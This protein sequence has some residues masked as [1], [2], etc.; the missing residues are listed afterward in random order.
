MSNLLKIRALGRFEA[1]KNNQIIDFLAKKAQALL[2]YLA[3]SPAR[4]TRG[5]LATLLWSEFSEERGR[6]NLRQVLSKL[7]RDLGE[8]VLS[9]G[10]TIELDGQQCHCD[11][12]E[13]EQLAKS[14]NSEDLLKALDLFRGDFLH[15]FILRE[16]SFDDW[17]ILQRSQL[18]RVA[19]EISDRLIN[20]FSIE[21]DEQLT[22]VLNRR[23]SMD[24]A[25][26]PAHRKM[27]ELYARTGRR[28][29]AQR[30]Y[31]DCCEILRRELDAEPS[32]E[33]KQLFATIQQGGY[34]NKKTSIPKEENTNA[35]SVSRDIPR[36]AIMPF[37]IIPKDADSYFADGM[38]EDIIMAL[39]RFGSLQVISRES[40]FTYQNQDK[41]DK[42]IA[43]ELSADYL[44]RGSVQ[45]AGD[46]LR[47]NVKLLETSSGVQLWG[48]RF[49][50][51]LQDIFLLQDEISS[52][53][54]SI[55]VG[56]VEAARLANARKAPPE[57][58]DAYDMLL[59]GKEYHHRFTAED[60]RQCINMFEQAI[61]RDPEYAVAYAWLACGFGQAMVF[62]LDDVAKLVDKSQA[63]AE[64]GLELDENESECHRLLAQ[65]HLERH[66]LKR[67]LWHQEKALLL[68][69]NDDR[70]VCS[71]GEILAYLG[72]YEEA[73]KW[74]RKSMQLNP[75]HAQRVWTHLARPLF[76]LQRYEEA[77]QALD[78][79]SRMRMDDYVYYL[80][81]CVKLGDNSQ[82]NCCLSKMKNHYSNFQPKAFVDS[83]PYDQD[84][85]ITILVDAIS[86][87]P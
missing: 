26:E 58:L 22:A 77:R 41:P 10:D 76:H 54:A 15:G 19:C 64:R 86:Q 78:H 66:D 24:P 21:Q 75:Y 7:R 68:N 34:E 82:L 1:E 70:S 51:E 38:V 52:T 18:R 35:S 74:V 30:Q 69:P 6:H 3:T 79:I 50:R 61:E 44:V 67:S 2:V 20:D 85:D 27:M 5:Q 65:I 16:Q 48:E 14:Q 37:D 49:D 80:A 11:V 81:C 36:V 55:I 71:M 13:F 84:V 87:I 47:I 63:A 45:R 42:T 25:C 39:S 8:I 33:T 72:R 57:R 9:R 40:T 12:T 32:E 59:R 23:L 83:L 29:D 17:L 31:Q 28:S 4:Q 43:N 62:E 53:L 60:C 56:Q 46:R 73:E